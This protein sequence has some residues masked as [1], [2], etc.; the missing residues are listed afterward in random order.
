MFEITQHDREYWKYEYDVMARY[1]L[2]LLQLWGVELEGT[3]ILDVGCGDGGGVSAMADAGMICEGFDIEPR[4]VE[5]ANILRGGRAFTMEVG[6]IYESPIPFDGELYDLVILHD[7]FEHLDRKPYVLE[8]LRSYLKPKGK[9]FLTFPPF[10]SAYGAHQQLLRS[11]VARI[12]FF[13]LLPFATSKILPSLQNE[14][15]PF[16][17]EIQKLAN[18][19]MGIGK[20]ERLLH[21]TQ[22]AIARREFYLIG[23]NHIRFGL[24]PLRAGMLGSIPLMRELFV[25]GAVYLLES[26]ESERTQ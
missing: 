22:I 18:L 1:L 23:P 15:R 11:S 25:T 8:T 9:I 13:H 19:K 24:K 16:I 20:F 4:R 14:H 3:R 17:E 12:P 7:V 5:L 21:T 26:K 6:N 2:P 10:Y